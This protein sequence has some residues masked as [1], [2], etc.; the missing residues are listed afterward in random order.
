MW[1]VRLPQN[2]LIPQPADDICDEGIFTLRRNP[3]ISLEILGREFSLLGDHVF[4]GPVDDFLKLAVKA[5]VMLSIT[6]VDKYGVISLETCRVASIDSTQKFFVQVFF[7]EIRGIDHVGV[8][9]KYLE[10]I[11]HLTS[12]LVRDANCSH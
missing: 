6:A 7:P 4:V 10:S 2:P 8:G 11:S 1:E 12:L 9:I 3:A 5:G